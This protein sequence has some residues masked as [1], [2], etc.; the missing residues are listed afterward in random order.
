LDL[1]DSELHQI[2]ASVNP[3]NALSFNFS[4]FVEV[5]TALCTHAK[6]CMLPIAAWLVPSMAALLAAA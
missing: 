5:R 2:I 6:I 1:A 4:K 3:E